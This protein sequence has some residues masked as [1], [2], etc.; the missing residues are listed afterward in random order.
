MTKTKPFQITQSMVLQAYKLVKANKGAGGV[1]E[2]SIELFEQNWKNN[3]YK[4]W[5][6]MASGTYFPPP[7]KAVSIPKK[8]GGTRI[9]GIPTVADR[10]A[11][12]VVKTSMEP[13]IE[14][15]FYADSYGYRP[16]KSALDAVEVTRSRCWK[17]DWL[18]EFDI[19]GLFDNINHELL[20]RTV[21]KHAKNRWEILYIGRWLTVSIVHSDGFSALRTKGVPQGGVI[22]PLL[23]NLFFTLCI[24]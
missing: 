16:N 23:A 14:P 4:I 7:V 20:M 3:L 8:S 11:Q 13:N 21:R 18:I 2:V 10:I 9:L 24:R 1:D 12:M 17:N 15:Y 6:R 5:N 22:S 19:V